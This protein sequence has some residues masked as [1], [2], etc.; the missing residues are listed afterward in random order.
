MSKLVFDAV[1]L[2]LETSG[3]LLVANMLPL[4]LGELLLHL[5]DGPFHGFLVKEV[6]LVLFL[7][8]LALQLYQLP[9]Q[10]LFRIGC[11]PRICAFFAPK[12]F[13]QLSILSLHYAVLFLESVHFVSCFQ[14]VMDLKFLSHDVLGTLSCLNKLPVRCALVSLVQQRLH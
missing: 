13:L 4:C 9:L 3:L 7:S 8:V 14:A 1:D 2:R 6:Q 12:M 11:F 5:T 10:S